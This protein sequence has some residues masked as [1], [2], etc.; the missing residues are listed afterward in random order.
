MLSFCCDDSDIKKFMNYMLNGNAFDRMQL[1]SGEVVTR[2]YF[3]FDGHLNREYDGIE[4]EREYCLWGEIRQNFFDIIK[5][6]KLPKYIKLVF[7]LDNA[8]LE[9]LHPNA[10]AAFLNVMFEGGHLSF[11]TGTAQK[12]FAL[13]KGLELEWEDKVKLMFKKLGIAII[14]R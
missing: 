2:G 14:T 1:R 8:A 7:A 5:G 4:E 12:S 13:D 11:T 10:R 6:K 9:K 3:S